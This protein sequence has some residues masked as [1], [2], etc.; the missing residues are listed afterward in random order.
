MRA[1]A[2][3]TGL[4][5]LA[6]LVSAAQEQ[7][8]GQVQRR[9]SPGSTELLSLRGIDTSPAQIGL[10]SSLV[11]VDV[12][13]VPPAP[14]PRGRATADPRYPHGGYRSGPRT[15]HRASTASSPLST[16]ATA[17]TVTRTMGNVG[18]PRASAARIAQPLC[19]APCRTGTSGTPARRGSCASARTAGAESTVMYARRTRRVRHSRAGGR[20]TGRRCRRG[21]CSATRGDWPCRRTSRCAT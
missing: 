11:S 16:V 21:T 14:R 1:V 13:H 15:A 8:Y 4:P 10:N 3:L 5:A 6:S 17:A 7:G 2:F 19:A 9:A 12:L 20:T 18:V